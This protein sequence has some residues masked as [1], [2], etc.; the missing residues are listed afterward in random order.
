MVFISVMVWTFFYPGNRLHAVSLKVGLVMDDFGG[1]DRRFNQLAYHGLVQAEKELGIKGSAVSAVKEEDFSKIIG[2]YVKGG[3]E[4]VIGNG[5]LMK[6]AFIEASQRFPGT[7]FVLTD[8]KLGIFPNLGSVVFASQ[9]VS[10]LAGSLAAMLDQ[11]QNI[12]FPIRHNGRLSIVAGKDIPSV[13]TSMAGFFQGARYINPNIKV[14][15]G[16]AGTFKD[17]DAAKQLAL[18]QNINGSDIIYTLAGDA[19][20]GVLAASNEAKFLT[21]GS[22]SDPDFSEANRVLTN[23]RKL[24]NV[25]VFQIVKD[26]L[27]GRFPSGKVIYDLKIGGLELTPLNRNVPEYISNRLEQIRYDIMNGWIRVGVEIPEWAKQQN[28]R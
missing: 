6:Q 9:E 11:D 5:V 10:F 26:T 24:Y 15:Y 25:V 23:T 1:H 2:R 8:V 17:A 22:G 27:Q 14:R 28:Q 18:N 7:K 21:I 19:G 3:Y 16:F 13:E 20:S 12:R 4:L